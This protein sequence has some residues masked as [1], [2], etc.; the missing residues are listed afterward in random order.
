MYLRVYTIYIKFFS[1]LF[2]FCNNIYW[3]TKN[4]VMFNIYLE[5]AFYL[6][7]ITFAKLPEAYSIFDSTLR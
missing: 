3:R 1:L 4:L 7:G 6:N 5:N 2:H